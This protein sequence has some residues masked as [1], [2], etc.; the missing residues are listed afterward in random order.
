MSDTPHNNEEV[1]PQC[2]VCPFEWRERYCRTPGGKAPKNC[3]SV[4]DKDLARAALEVMKA[5]KQLYEFAHQSCKQE[6]A[7]YGNREL[8]Y[9]FVKPIK[10]RIL[11]IVEFARRMQFERIGLAFC[12]GLRTE[13]KIV[14]EFFE[15]AGFET[16]SIMC[17]AGRIPKSELGIDKEWQV[18]TEADQ[19]TTCHPV[20]QAM[21]ANRH[22]VD[23]CVLLGLCV[24]HDSMF[25]KFCEAPVTVLA[26]KD[27][28]FGHDPIKAVYQINHYYRYLKKEVEKE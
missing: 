4:H 16:F 12:G 6:A 11:E 7:G 28:V 22:K 19:E 25:I 10:P 15:Q 13:A 24:G 9:E 3:P 27:R 20:F 17:K 23:F 14:H 18:D 21:A 8:G 5:D 2:A 26:A 1:L